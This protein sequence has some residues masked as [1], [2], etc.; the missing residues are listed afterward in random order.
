MS[1]SV[2]SGS[3]HRRRVNK[4]ILS[5]N[6][7]H[8]PLSLEEL[9]RIDNVTAAAADGGGEHWRVSTDSVL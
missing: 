6:S 3:N 2:Q 5:F 9:T 1:I 4:L 7:T 8:Q